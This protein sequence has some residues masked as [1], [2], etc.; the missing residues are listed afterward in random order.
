GRN[1][2]VSLRASDGGPAPLDPLGSAYWGSRRGGHDIPK[3]FLAPLHSGTPPLPT[4][5]AGGCLAAEDPDMPS[6]R[7]PRTWQATSSRW[8]RSTGSRDTGNRKTPR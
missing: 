2:I 5:P 7:G 6:S 4:G 1:Q 8:V 3:T